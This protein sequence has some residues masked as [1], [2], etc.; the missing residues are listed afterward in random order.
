MAVLAVLLALWGGDHLD[1]DRAATG[2]GIFAISLFAV[3][4]GAL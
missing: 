4:R 2:T 3:R 1:L